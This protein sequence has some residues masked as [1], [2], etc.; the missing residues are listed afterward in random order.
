MASKYTKQKAREL[1]GEINKPTIT[2]GNFYHISYILCRNKKDMKNFNN[3][4][5]YLET[6]GREEDC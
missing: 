6:R 2:T 5:N 1:E 3:T 4:I